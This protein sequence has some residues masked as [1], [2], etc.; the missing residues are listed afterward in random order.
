MRPISK[1]GPKASG[2]RLPRSVMDSCLLI[3]FIRSM[4]G[5]GL[6]SLLKTQRCVKRGDGSPPP[7][8]IIRFVRQ[9]VIASGLE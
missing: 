6:E 2:I 7:H 1:D 9:Q 4:M 5:K 8:Y 3:F